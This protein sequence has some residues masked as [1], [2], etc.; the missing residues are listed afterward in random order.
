MDTNGDGVPNVIGID[1]TGNG[2]VDTHLVL[3]PRSQQD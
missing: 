3:T 2:C 1:S